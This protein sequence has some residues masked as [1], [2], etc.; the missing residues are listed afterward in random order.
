[1]ANNTQNVVFSILSDENGKL[2]K[3]ILNTMLKTQ[4]PKYNHNTIKT[5]IGNQTDKFMLY[6][7]MIT[8]IK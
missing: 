3:N 6:L 8:N 7:Y 4:A 5:S 1:M 2:V